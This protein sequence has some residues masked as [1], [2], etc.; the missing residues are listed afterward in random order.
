MFILVV[1]LFGTKIISLIKMVNMDSNIAMKIEM[2]FKTLQG[3][4]SW[5]VIF[6][7]IKI[8]YTM[9]PDLIMGHYLLQW[10]G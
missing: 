10:G 3:P 4:I 5:L 1:P 7:L 9:A 6:M 8:L 2:I